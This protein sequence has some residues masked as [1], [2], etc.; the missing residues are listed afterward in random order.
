MFAI[1]CERIAQPKCC[2]HHSETKDIRDLSIARTS[3]LQDLDDVEY[4]T[5]HD[6]F[7]QRVLASKTPTRNRVRKN[8]VLH[9]GPC[10]AI[11]G[12]F[13]EAQVSARAPRVFQLRHSRSVSELGSQCL[14]CPPS[15]RSGQIAGGYL[16]RKGPGLFHVGLPR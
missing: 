13:G 9:A 8:F 14:Q 3:H 12:V 11:I 2:S 1:T 4:E 16:F 15:F 6:L 10:G 7:V 5:R